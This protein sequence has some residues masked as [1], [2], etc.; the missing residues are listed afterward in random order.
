[1]GI[2]IGVWGEKGRGG[3]NEEGGE[4]GGG[5][6]VEEGQ[7]QTNNSKVSLWWSNLTKVWN[8]EE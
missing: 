7:Q 2:L 8:S 4:G 3:V 5:G 6:V 1:V